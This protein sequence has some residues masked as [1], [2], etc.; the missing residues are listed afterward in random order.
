MTITVHTEGTHGNGTFDQ[1]VNTA[2]DATDESGIY[3]TTINAS[4]LYDQ[5]DAQ[6]AFNLRLTATTTNGL[7]ETADVTVSPDNATV[8]SL[9]LTTS[10]DDIVADGASTASSA[11]PSLTMAACPSAGSLYSSI[12]PPAPLRTVQGPPSPPPQ[13]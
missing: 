9:A 10:D 11:P 6:L 12:S 1:L 8:G 2:S 7:S 5:D 3:S 13:A 4:R